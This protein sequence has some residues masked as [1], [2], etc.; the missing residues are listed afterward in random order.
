MYTACLPSHGQVPSNTLAAWG[1]C[2]PVCPANGPPPP[3]AVP[4]FA[5][6]LG[7]EEKHKWAEPWMCVAFPS[8][9][10]TQA[11]NLPPP[12]E[13]HPAKN[14]LAPSSPCQCPYLGKAAFHVTQ[15]DTHTGGVPTGDTED[16]QVTA[17]P[18]IFAFLHRTVKQCRE[19]MGR[20][21]YQVTF[22]FTLP[23]PLTSSLLYT[24]CCLPRRIMA[25]SSWK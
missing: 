2:A 16:L 20:A 21:R 8:T 24:A 13:P 4:I 5:L 19:G 23:I 17:V 22:C 1:P 14:T 6:L 18:A 9:T 10:N 11:P 7:M 12:R 25:S 3:A 15:G